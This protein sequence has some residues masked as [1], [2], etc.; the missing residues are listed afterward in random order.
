MKLNK[1]FEILGWEVSLMYV[2]GLWSF[3]LLGIIVWY[4]ETK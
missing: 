1:F 4:M 3:T 2:I